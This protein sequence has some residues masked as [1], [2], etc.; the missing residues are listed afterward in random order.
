M[1]LINGQP[2]IQTVSDGAAG[3][4]RMDHQAA[5]VVQE[6]NPV[7]T[8]AVYRGICFAASVPP[9]TGV[10]ATTTIAVTGAMFT[11]ANPA[12][13]G[14]NLVLQEINYGFIS[15][16]MSSGLI[17]LLAHNTTPPIVA[18][19]GGTAITPQNMLLGAATNSVANCRF[20][21]TVPASGVVIRNLFNIGIQIPATAQ[22]GQPATYYLH[23]GV[24]VAPGTA[25]SVQA[26]SAAVTTGLCVIGAVWIEQPV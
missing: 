16:T 13:S 4:A 24:L 9:G 12:T 19:A 11:L 14:K 7:L 2:G 10:V 23:G 5:L 8:E 18:P 21:N 22:F 1:V 17:L 15:G 3:V 6:A 26:Q 20:S 25:V